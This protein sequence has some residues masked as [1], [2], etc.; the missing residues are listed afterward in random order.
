MKYTFSKQLNDAFQWLKD[1][2]FEDTVSF[3]ET[4][5]ELGDIKEAREANS[6]ITILLGFVNMFKAASLDDNNE[7]AGL[8]QEY[9]DMFFWSMPPNH[10]KVILSKLD[11]DGRRRGVEIGLGFKKD[12][13]PK[14]VLTLLSA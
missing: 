5:P 2:G 9:F 4:A 3:C 8:F 14:M 6:W 13:D 10:R 7:A 12:S 1:N 11:E